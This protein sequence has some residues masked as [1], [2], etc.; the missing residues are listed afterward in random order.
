MGQKKEKKICEQDNR[1]VSEYE[2]DRP[3]MNNIKC[4]IARDINHDNREICKHVCVCLWKKMQFKKL[5][6][7]DSTDSNEMKEYMNKHTQEKR[8][9]EK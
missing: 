5:H 9:R 2:Q 1:R 3:A 4:K 8:Q 6:A 7:N